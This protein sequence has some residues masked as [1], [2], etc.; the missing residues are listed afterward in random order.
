MKKCMIVWVPIDLIK[1]IEEERSMFR[2]EVDKD[3]YDYQYF[4][5][6]ETIDDE[7]INN[8]FNQ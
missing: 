4:D 7:Y 2:N 1:N 6:F 5:E 8:Q 3:I